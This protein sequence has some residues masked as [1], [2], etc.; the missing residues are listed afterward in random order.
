MIV[1][2]LKLK[3]NVFKN[4]FCLV[5]VEPFPFPRSCTLLYLTQ[6]NVISVTIPFKSLYTRLVNLQRFG[7]II[8]IS[9]VGLSAN[10]NGIFSFSTVVNS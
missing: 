6:H 2:I 8:P 9:N 7:S 3:C 5:T 10:F 1:C 4:S